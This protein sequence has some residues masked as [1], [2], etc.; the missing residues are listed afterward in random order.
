MT[1]SL[2]PVF[3]VFEGL[4][5]SGK[6]TCA[7]RAA[8]VLGACYLKTPSGP[9]LDHRESI[10][11]SFNGSQE[12]AQLLYL[13]SVVDASR[14][15]KTHL[16][17]GQSVVLD[18]YLLSTQVYAE[19]RGST[20]HIDDAIS[21]VLRAADLTVFLDAPLAVRRTRMSA[22]SHVVAADDAETLSES[23]DL[24]LREGYRRRFCLPVT[25]RALVL[26]SSRLDINEIASA[27]AADLEQLQGEDA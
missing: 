12:A 20:L 5:G 7:R 2:N 8:A 4:D 14:I 22:R 15:A 18:R 16:A 13:A 3:V 27:V 1:P 21:E 9:L 26:D 25:G 17:A 11:A 10:I 24:A 6:S 19:F 23:A